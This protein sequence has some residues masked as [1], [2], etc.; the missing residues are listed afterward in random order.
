MQCD[1]PK[2]KAKYISYCNLRD[3]DC[4]RFTEIASSLGWDDLTDL[5][6][7]HEITNVV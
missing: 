4:D 5:Q 3:F 7:V 1:K 6:D 2:C